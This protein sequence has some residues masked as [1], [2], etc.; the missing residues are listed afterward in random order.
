[1]KHHKWNHLLVRA[2]PHDLI[3]WIWSTRKQ[4]PCTMPAILL[5]PPRNRQWD[6]RLRHAAKVD[7]KPRPMIHSWFA[8][9]GSHENSCDPQNNRIPVNSSR[10]SKLISKKQTH[11][12]PP[13]KKFPH[14]SIF[15]CM[16]QGSFTFFISQ[17]LSLCCSLWWI[18]TQLRGEVRW[19]ARSLYGHS[20]FSC[21]FIE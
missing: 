20:T 7:N 14:R 10:F 9:L 17:L 12:K 11:T 5:D 6:T 8:A 13:K 2:P 19:M 15:A 21:M 1:M 4:V 3:F 16:V 18:S